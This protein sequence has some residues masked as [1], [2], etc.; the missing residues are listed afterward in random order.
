VA[1]NVQGFRLAVHRVTGEVRILQSVHAADA[2]TVINPVQCR[3]QVEGAVMQ[4]IGWALYEHM[5]TDGTGKVV[6]PTFRNYRIPAFADAPRTEVL[7]AD[8]YDAIGPG[9]SKGMGECPVN[10]VAPALVNAI[11]DATGIWFRTLP[12]TPDRLFPDLV[13]LADTEQALLVTA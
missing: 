9:G 13:A 2:G 7:F 11:A 4:G 12:L 1:F 8:T 6:N 10:P 3:G 5:E